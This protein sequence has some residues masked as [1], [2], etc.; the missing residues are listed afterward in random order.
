MESKY[1]EKKLLT[2]SLLVSNRKDTI[3]KCMESIKPLLEALPS[4]LIAVDTGCTDGSIDIVREYADLIVDFPWCHDFSAARNAGLKKA[5]GE[6]FLY[7]DDDEWFEDVTEIIDFFQSG[8]YKQYDRAWY[9]V[10]NYYDWDGKTYK[11]SMADRVYKRTPQAR[12][13]G[14]V[15]E[16]YMPTSSKIKH[17][18]C[19]AHHYGYVYKSKEAEKK[20]SERNINLLK[21]EL[22]ENPNDI[23]MIAQ[24]IQEYIAADNFEEA[25]K[26]RKNTLD[27]YKPE[28]CKNVVFQYIITSG[29]VILRKE[30]KDEALAQLVKEIMD[31]YPLTI[32][33]KLVCIVEQILVLAHVEKNEEL[34]SKLPEYFQMH[35]MVKALGDSTKEEDYFDRMYYKSNSLHK[36][37][38]GIG[39]RVAVALKRNQLIREY[40]NKWEQI[41]GPEEFVEQL[42]WYADILWKWYIREE[43]K[44]LFFVYYKDF[45]DNSEIKNEAYEELEELVVKYPEKRTDL[46]KGF[47]SLHRTEP[48]FVFLHLLYQ[49]QQES[50]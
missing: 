50:F 49:L 42:L 8:E 19:Y 48:V 12:F 20:H 23:R 41:A 36:R 35:D 4:E 9:V 47:E 6:W 37:I 1:K 11:E 32:L 46:A 5:Q 31:I 25:R 34:V 33:S 18:S 15:H 30:G 45:L 27:R 29:L 44:G 26:W 3:R 16:A 2:I 21:K 13:V 40:L 10:R 22:E 39:F 43:D 17:L 38:V 14:K 7:L 28:Q 24:L